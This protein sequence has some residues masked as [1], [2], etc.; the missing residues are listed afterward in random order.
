MFDCVTCSPE[1]PSWLLKVIFVLCLFRLETTLVLIPFP[2][3]DGVVHWDAS[4]DDY[5]RFFWFVNVRH[6]F[7]AFPNAGTRQISGVFTKQL[8]LDA[9][10]SILP[11][12]H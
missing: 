10:A 5:T 1:L 7:D 11:N 2:D 4:I 12:P 9:P 6:L 3:L 8:F